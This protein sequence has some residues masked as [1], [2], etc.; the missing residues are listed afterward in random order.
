MKAPNGASEGAVGHC[1][2][3]KKI[4]W[5]P[6]VERGAARMEATGGNRR[7]MSKLELHGA[8]MAAVELA[9]MQHSQQPVVCYVNTCLES[10]TDEPDV[11]NDHLARA[12]GLLPRVQRRQQRLGLVAQ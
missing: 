9:L 3:Q 5:P 12:I 2:G 1:G 4:G 11:I 7:N 10:C 8:A 6:R